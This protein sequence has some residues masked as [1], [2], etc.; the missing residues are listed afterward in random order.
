MHQEH[1]G[2]AQMH[3]EHHGEMLEIGINQLEHMTRAGTRAGTR[4]RAGTMTRTA[5]K[6]LSKYS[7]HLQVLGTK[8]YCTSPGTKRCN[9]SNRAGTRAG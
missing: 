6:Q 9:L 1:N 2:Q 7:H 4:T 8:R 3:Q 5:T